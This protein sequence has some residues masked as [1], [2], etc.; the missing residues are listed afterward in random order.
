M[1]SLIVAMDERNGIGLNGRLPWHLSADLKRFKE[2]TMGHHV[3]M[4]RKTYT[5][6]GRSLPGRIQ[7][8]ITHDK[9]FQAENVL[10]AESF[11]AALELAAAGGETEAFVIGGSQIFREALSLAERIYLTRVHAALD[12]DVFFPALDKAHWQETCLSTYP[13]DAKNDFPYSF[14]ILE[15]KDTGKQESM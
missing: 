6:I 10:T 11:P 8:V 9:E 7:V 4:G 12:A 5:S 14:Y 1:I 2:L 15:K 3:L 13:A